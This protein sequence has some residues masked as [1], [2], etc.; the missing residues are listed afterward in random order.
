MNIKN[1]INRIKDNILDM[2]V[3]SKQFLL[4]IVAMIILSMIFTPFIGIPVGLILGA[5]LNEK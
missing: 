3:K 2:N 4:M 1:Y 5:Y